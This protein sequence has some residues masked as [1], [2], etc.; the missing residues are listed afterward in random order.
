MQNGL[1]WTQNGFSCRVSNMSNLRQ[2]DGDDYPEAAGRHL[3]DAGVLLAGN[4]HDG[5]AY[6]AGY[7]VECA[8]KTLIQVETGK[9]PRRSHDL[10]ALRDAIGVLAVQADTRTGRLY[11]GV[12]SKASEVLEWRP[13]I[14]Y[15][16][17]A[18]PS[19]T[20]RAWFGEASEVYRGVVGSLILDGAI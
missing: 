2:Q 15:H 4:R 3:Q 17:Q 19:H 10:I 16:G 9:P 7:V 14:R 11:T 20:A 18:V 6:L 5:A 12:L 13:E 8:M 1:D